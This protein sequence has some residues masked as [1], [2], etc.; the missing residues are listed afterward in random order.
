MNHSE[1]INELSLALA[2]AQGKFQAIKRSKS[3]EV[4]G[5]TR[6]GR[7]FKY[8]YA[9]AP[10]DEILNATRPA[11][12]ENGLALIQTTE[13]GDRGTLLKTMLVHGSGQWVAS[14]KALGHFEDPQK[15]GGALTYYRRYEISAILGISSEE[16]DDANGV[17]G[18]ETKRKPQTNERL[19]IANPDTGEVT[20]LKPES[21]S[22]NVG[23]GHDKKSSDATTAFWKTA[24]NMQL[25]KEKALVIL[26]NAGGDFEVALDRLTGT[27]QEPA[28]GDGGY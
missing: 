6:D 22:G 24:R 1:Q 16:D 10:L 21:K 28:E 13:E 20:Q 25:T 7:D 9:Y 8:K 23:N 3:V 27:A 18:N 2:K 26:A 14:Y 17:V 19:P 4:A 11:L 15:F 12:S 5:K